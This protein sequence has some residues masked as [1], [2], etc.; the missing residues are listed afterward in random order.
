MCD[1]KNNQRWSFWKF[2]FRAPIV[3]AAQEKLE[4]FFGKLNEKEGQDKLDKF[5]A[6]KSYING[7]Q[8]SKLDAK[9]ADLVGECSDNLVDLSR[10]LKHV[11]SF[12]NHTILTDGQIMQ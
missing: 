8:M 11:K 1:S 9:A 3:D 5:L 2:I 6:D 10:W 7:F 4:S 12:K